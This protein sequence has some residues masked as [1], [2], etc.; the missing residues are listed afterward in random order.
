MIRAVGC[1]ILRERLVGAL[2]IDVDELEATVETQPRLPGYSHDCLELVEGISFIPKLDSISS[3]TWLL[4]VN[5]FDK[6]SIVASGL[7]PVIHAP[8]QR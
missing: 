7:R 1:D 4:S 6:Q 5:D 2:A 8:S 3:L